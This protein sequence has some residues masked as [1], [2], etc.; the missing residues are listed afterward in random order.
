MCKEQLKKYELSLSKHFDVPIEHLRK[1]AKLSQEE[2]DLFI[3]GCI[4]YHTS[5]KLKELIRMQC[6]E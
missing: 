6:N 4:H 3:F 2:F 5:K 1:C